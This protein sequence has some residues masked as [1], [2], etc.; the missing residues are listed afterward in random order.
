MKIKGILSAI[1]AISIA[2]LII[3][4]SIGLPIYF[5]PFYYLQ[6]EPLGLPE[7]TGRSYEE[8]KTAYNE[9]L[10]Y[11]VYP[12]GEFGSGVFAFSPD[13]AS[14]FADCKGL[15]TLNGVALLVSL[16]L[17]VT[18]FVLQRKRIVELSRPGG[19][20]IYFWS[21]VSVLSAFALI[22][23]LAASDF[24]RAFE[25]FH[26]IF[27]PGKDNWVF[28]PRADEIIRAMP[29]EFFMNCGILIL[30]SVIILSVLA[31]VFGAI[32]KKKTNKKYPRR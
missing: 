22:G 28:D 26:T 32:A 17:V 7:S 24:E 12:G 10:D 6:I 2:V 27:F 9:V 11:L 15:F 4:F 13:G 14:H 21:G 23:V 18:I 1:L 5:R 20:P 25:V 29:E 31:V 30:S 19:F 8:I 3:T 16:A